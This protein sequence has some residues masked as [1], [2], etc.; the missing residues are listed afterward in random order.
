M[1][2]TVHDVG[3]G[4]CVSLQHENGNAMLW[5]SGNSDIN[6]P[7][8]FLPA[9]GATKVD[10]F[11]VTNYDEDHISDLPNLRN[12]VNLRSLIRNKSI[13]SAQLR[14]LKLQSGPITPA[15]E[16]MLNMMDTYTDGPLDP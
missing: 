14:A 1:R 10:N 2:V 11:F 3:H 4:L 12:K 8:V 16:S 7:S 15:M 6:R 9:W 13:S 5:D